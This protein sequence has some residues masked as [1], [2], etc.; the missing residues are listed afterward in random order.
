M[1]K[2]CRGNPDL[3]RRVS[4]P[5]PRNEELEARLRDW[6]SPGTFANLKTVSDKNRQ[7]RDR[8]LTLLV[9]VAIVL[10]LI[11][12]QMSGLNEA[13]RVLEQ[14]GLMWVD[15][16]RV[17]RQAL[18]Q[19][20]RTLSARLFAQLLEQVL[21]QMQPQ[22]TK[23]AV[24]CGWQS[25]EQRFGAI[26]VADG[27]ILEAIAKKLNSL[28]SNA[29][30]VGG[31]MMM[32]V[33]AFSHRPVAAWY[34]ADAQAHDQQWNDVLLERL[35]R[36]GLLIFDLGCFNFVWFDACTQ[37]H[38]YF[39]TRWKQKTAGQVIRV[40]TQGQRYRDEIVELGRYAP[41]PVVIRCG[42]SR[43]YG[44]PNGTPILPMCLTQPCY[45]R[46]R[47]VTFIANDGGLRKPFC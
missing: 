24:P 30:Q 5:A 11:Y 32:I 36:G 15:A 45:P 18:S 1:S 33:E 13:L 2:H 41:I 9:M 3:R 47:W 7:L 35:P 25:V 42:E 34:R 26:W 44:A 22:G 19:R 14:Q 43:S 31:K 4:P 23:A 37:A 46:N 27:S 38:K 16:Q 28:Q 17:T 21:A 12:R 10:S 20:L 8:I 39:L 29:S 40:L 6:L